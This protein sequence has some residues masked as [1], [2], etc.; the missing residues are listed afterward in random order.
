MAAFSFLSIDDLSISSIL[1]KNAEL[2]NLFNCLFA[3]TYHGKENAEVLAFTF[4]LIRQKPFLF[5]SLFSGLPV[6]KKELNSG[7][8]ALCVVA[9]S[10]QHKK[11]K[12]MKPNVE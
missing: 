11:G 5:K 2:K 4:F 1:W 12:D 6:G 10:R 9:D 8:N 7:S 3:W